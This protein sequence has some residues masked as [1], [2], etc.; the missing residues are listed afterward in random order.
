M[1]SLEDSIERKGKEKTSSETDGNK[2]RMFNF[3]ET[4]VTGRNRQTAR[5]FL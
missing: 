2:G 3:W 1:E 4:G 5:V